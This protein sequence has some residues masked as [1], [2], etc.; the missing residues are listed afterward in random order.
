MYLFFFWLYR[1]LV[2][3]FVTHEKVE[4]R[5]PFRTSLP[6]STFGV[7]RKPYTNKRASSP[8]RKSLGNKKPERLFLFQ[9]KKI[10]REKNSWGKKFQGILF[11]FPGRKCLFPGRKFLRQ[12]IL[13]EKIPR[14]FIPQEKNSWGKKFL[15]IRNNIP[16]V[17]GKKSSWKGKFIPEK[18]S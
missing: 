17:F 9:R 5:Q 18:I 10:Y 12:K 4:R 16:V 2:E 15:G 14:N 11:L 3:A 7:Q 1:F 8:G 6:F 13:G